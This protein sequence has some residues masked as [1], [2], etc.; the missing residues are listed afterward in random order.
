MVFLAIQKDMTHRSLIGRKAGRGVT[1]PAAGSHATMP[2]NDINW[3]KCI[4]GC[5]PADVRRKAQIGL[6]ARGREHY[7][8]AYRQCIWVVEDDALTRFRP[9]EGYG[10]AEWVENV[11]TAI[12]WTDLFWSPGS[13]V[14][15]LAEL[16]P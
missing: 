16:V 13:M 14:D 10:L 11:E 2:N 4:D 3:Q 6:D 9:R 12:G 1:A 5:G 15:R 7:W 8:D